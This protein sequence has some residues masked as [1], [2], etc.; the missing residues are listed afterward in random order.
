MKFKAAWLAAACSLATAASAHAASTDFATI[1]NWVAYPG[2]SG[3]SN[4]GVTLTYVGTPGTIWTTSQPTAPSGYSWYVPGSFGYT[5]ISLTGGGTFTDAALLVG[6]GYGGTVPW[7]AYAFVSNGTVVA[8][9]DWSTL[10]AYG[11]GLVTANLSSAVPITD[12]W[13]QGVAGAEPFSNANLDAL[14]IAQVSLSGGPSAVPEPASWSLALAGLA[15]LGIAAR[16][17]RA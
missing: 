7:L 11:D 8:T 3:Y 1:G 16:R 4:G 14:A 13:L 17:R 6:T 5:D 2:A 15:A 10:P 9:G 12:L